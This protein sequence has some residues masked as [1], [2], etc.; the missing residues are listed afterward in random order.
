MFNPSFATPETIRSKTP[1]VQASRS[2]IRYR[3]PGLWHEGA[4]CQCRITQAQSSVHFVYGFGWK[5]TNWQANY[6]WHEASIFVTNFLGSQNS[7]LHLGADWIPAAT[8]QNNCPTRLKTKKSGSTS[9]L[10]IILFWFFLLGKEEWSR[11]STLQGL[12]DWFH[13]ELLAICIQV[14]LHKASIFTWRLFCQLVGSPMAPSLT[15][16]VSEQARWAR[17]ACGYHHDHGKF[18]TCLNQ[19]LNQHFEWSIED[20]VMQDK[21]NLELLAVFAHLGSGLQLKL[22]LSGS[23]WCS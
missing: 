5:V 3:H 10:C 20:S 16:R 7:S 4:P 17:N 6:I 23:T 1:V 9:A 21:K 11:L 22:G 14:A 18:P 13:K 12:H 19:C 15:R 2:H 8:V